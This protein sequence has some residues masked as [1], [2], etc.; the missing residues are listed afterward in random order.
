MHVGVMEARLLNPLEDRII[1]TCEPP[2]VGAVSARNGI[3]VLC[4]SIYALNH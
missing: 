2:D 3:L 4:K 1:S